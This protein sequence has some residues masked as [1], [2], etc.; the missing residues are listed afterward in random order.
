MVPSR[1]A[2]R[3]SPED[4][5]SELAAAAVQMHELFAEYVKAGFTRAEALTLIS[6]LIRPR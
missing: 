6:E 3:M 4:P 5:I 2:R 1:E